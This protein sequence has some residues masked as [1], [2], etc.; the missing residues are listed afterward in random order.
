ML[1]AMPLW[2]RFLI[3]LIIKGGM[4]LW[5]LIKHICKPQSCKE[6][7]CH[8]YVHELKPCDVCCSVVTKYECLL[9]GHYD[10]V[11]FENT[12]EKCPIKSLDKVIKKLIKEKKNVT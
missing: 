6:C 1:L 5:I 12:Y 2:N 11:S 3:K 7:N 8:K 9:D 4:F 10:F